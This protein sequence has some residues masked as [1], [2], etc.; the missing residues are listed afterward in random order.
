MAKSITNGLK[1]TAIIGASGFIGSKLF[2]KYRE[3]F[4]DTF[5]TSSKE[6]SDLYCY[7]LRD[8]WPFNVDLSELGY[9]S[10]IIA[11]GVT[12][13][14]ECE[15]RY[16]ETYEVNV[17]STINL[18][19]ELSRNGL[20]V[21]FLSSD[22]VFS[23]DNPPYGDSAITTPRTAYGQ[24]K[25]IVESVIQSEIKTA[26]I[27]RLSRAYSLDVKDPHVISGIVNQIVSGKHQKYA[28]DQR[29]KPIEISDVFKSIVAI[30][31]SNVTG[32]VNVCGAESWSRY[33]IAHSIIEKLGLSPNRIEQGTLAELA[34]G[35]NLPS[36]TSMCT[37]RLN[38]L[39]QVYPKGLSD[40]LNLILEPVAIGLNGIGQ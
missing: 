5:G 6:K 29:F 38:D 17:V 31:A 36:D 22:Y 27:V 40:H 7:D 20:H 28:F 21:L 2:A 12:S 9:E 39:C 3:A 32:V 14:A 33:E 4:S 23:G 35:L 37:Q 10:V 24:Q 8:R 19:K 11:A 18:A 34:A 16:K 26:T 15:S 1:K 13:V 25:S 30:Q